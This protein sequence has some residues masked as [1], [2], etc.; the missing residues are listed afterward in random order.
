[1]VVWG[2]V[3]G[4]LGDQAGVRRPVGKLRLGIVGTWCQLI[5]ACINN[6]RCSSTGL[7][8]DDCTGAGG[9]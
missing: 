8:V 1:M 3:Q 7:T 6:M 5:G 9:C 2:D 4:A